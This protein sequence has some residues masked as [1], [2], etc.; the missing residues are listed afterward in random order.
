[1]FWKEY[2]QVTKGEEVVNSGEPASGSGKKRSLEGD[3]DIDIDMV[4]VVNLIG[5]WV[6]EIQS[7]MRKDGGEQEAWD[8]MKGRELFMDEVKVARKEKY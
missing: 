6:T 3:E 1:M 2:D 5:E 8:D 7:V 4:E